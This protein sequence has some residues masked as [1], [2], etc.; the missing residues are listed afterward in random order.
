M[1]VCCNATDSEHVSRNAFEQKISEST[2][3][4]FVRGQSTDPSELCLSGPAKIGAT[5]LPKEGIIS[6]PICVRYLVHYKFN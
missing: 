4:H 1:H 5:S 2:T 3:H 6:I